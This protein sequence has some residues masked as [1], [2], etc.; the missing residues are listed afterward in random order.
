[1]NRRR[2]LRVAGSA[3]L[4]PSCFRSEQ[5]A[6]AAAAPADGR[7]MVRPKHPTGRADPGVWPLKLAV[8][9]DGL[10]R[11]PARYRAEAPT[12]LLL[13]LHGATGSGEASVHAC[14]AAADDAGLILCAP[15]SRG[16][17]WDI[18]RGSYGP[19]VAYINAA[20]TFTFAQCN[21]DPRRLAIAGFSD[22]ASYALSLGLINGDL[23][24]HILGFSPGFIGPVTSHGKPSIY[25]S[26]GT[27]DPILPIEMASRRIVSDLRR[28]GYAVQFREFAGGHTVPADI[29]AEAFGWANGNLTQTART[30][31]PET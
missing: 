25:V 16:M 9:R 27:S 21:V 4:L 15:D 14:G 20:L 12:G 11:V 23:F 13:M 17:T 19:D 3:L 24:S 30:V 5:E 22:G 6:L 2:F 7:L 29:M 26:H 8:G 31:T 28:R 10:L 1:M 18:V